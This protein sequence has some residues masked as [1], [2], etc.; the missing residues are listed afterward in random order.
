MQ[1]TMEYWKL[2]KKRNSGVNTYI[3]VDLD[4]NIILKKQGWSSRP[5]PVKK[6]VLEK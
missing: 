5:Q 2:I 6:I 3:L 1:T 4:D